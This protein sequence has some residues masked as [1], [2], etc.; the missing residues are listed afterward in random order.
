MSA[1]E[2]AFSWRDLWI[3]CAKATGAKRGF[4]W[5][6]RAMALAAGPERRSLG[7]E[8]LAKESRKTKLA[9]KIALCALAAA[10]GAWIAQCEVSSAA[11]NRWILMDANSSWA[12]TPQG[13]LLAREADGASLGRWRAIGSF[14]LFERRDP[15][16]E[17]AQDAALACLRAGACRS[18]TLSV[19]EAT[20]W[21]RAGLAPARWRALGASAWSLAACVSAWGLALSLAAG[22]AGA[23]GVW[24]LA[25]WIGIGWRR[26]PLLGL[27]R[28]SVAFGFFWVLLPAGLLLTSGSFIMGGPTSGAEAMNEGFWKTPAS[29]RVFRAVQSG[30]ARA[31]DMPVAVRQRSGEPQWV[32][33]EDGR[34]GWS[35]RDWDNCVAAKACG[36]VDKGEWAAWIA[37]QWQ[38]HFW[39]VALAVWLGACA[40]MGYAVRAV[41][42]FGSGPR[43]Q[44][45]HETLK[46]LKELGR[47]E[48]EQKEL[49]AALEGV[50]TASGAA[51]PA[52]R[53]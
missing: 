24:A 52:K 46:K 19:A 30:A 4:G 38:L 8:R 47:P 43:E 28:A 23:A 13:R 18:E 20:A 27:A 37:G 14:A 10:A 44:K 1:S 36:D 2:T 25:S 11:P 21:R 5:L 41:R 33:S 32:D 42:R 31:A 35:A 40:L 49:L 17:G 45:M 15:K 6:G 51:R 29:P 48:R 7:S 3:G 34:A 26:N 9:V 50:P 16:G 39:H 12:A 22:A 53:I